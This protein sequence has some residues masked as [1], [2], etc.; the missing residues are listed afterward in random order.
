[1][2]I[3]SYYPTQ[4]FLKTITTPLV[5]MMI[6]TII[7]LIVYNTV[8]TNSSDGEED[9]GHNNKD[10]KTDI[11]R[12]TKLSSHI[13]HD[14]RIF[15]DDYD[16]YNN[17][18]SADSFDIENKYLIIFINDTVNAIIMYD[19]CHI[20]INNIAYTI[21]NNNGGCAIADNNN[22]SSILSFKSRYKFKHNKINAENVV[23]IIVPIMNLLLLL[24]EMV[25]TTIITMHLIILMLLTITFQLLTMLLTPM[26]MLIITMLLLLSLSMV[27][28]IKKTLKLLLATSLFWSS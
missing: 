9:L 6:L 1:M 16:E 21:C 27:M 15:Y 25:S 23:V 26:V 28:L 20:Q 14:T 10:V 19:S 11:N 18:V 2:L 8:V 12:Q 22:I 7:L 17:Y 3:M 5:T 13:K 4:M 24:I